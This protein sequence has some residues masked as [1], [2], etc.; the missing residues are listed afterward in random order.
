MLCLTFL[1]ECDKCVAQNDLSRVLARRECRAW[2]KR[3]VYTTGRI[4]T[5]LRSSRV[6][7]RWGAIVCWKATGSYLALK[8][9]SSEQHI[10]AYVRRF[11]GRPDGTLKL[12]ER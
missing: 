4:Q 10:P 5:C 12:C 2:V 8:V 6:T 1:T 3:Q 7:S 9:P 11:P